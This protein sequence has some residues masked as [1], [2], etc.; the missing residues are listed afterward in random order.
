MIMILGLIYIVYTMMCVCVQGIHSLVSSLMATALQAIFM[1]FYIRAFILAIPQVK[2]LSK[3]LLF[4]L[5]EFIYQGQPWA[6]PSDGHCFFFTPFQ[7]IRE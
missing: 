1:Y 2:P 7:Y 5:R 4:P 3:I 6:K